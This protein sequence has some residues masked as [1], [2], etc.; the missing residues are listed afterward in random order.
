MKRLIKFQRTLRSN[1]WSSSN[2]VDLCHLYTFLSPP[3][4][5]STWNTHLVQDDYLI[6]IM[7]IIIY[8]VI[9]KPQLSYPS[10]RWR[11]P[12]SWNGHTL[13]LLPQNKWINKIMLITKPRMVIIYWTN[14]FLISILRSTPNYRCPNYYVG[15]RHVYCPHALQNQ[16][17]SA[18]IYIYIYRCIRPNWASMYIWPIGG[19]F[20]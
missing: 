16:M 4:S 12:C 1:S 6:Q 19:L 10:S 9:F 20:K 11:F 17:S 5:Y 7:S 2:D 15:I 13:L 8:I 3:T 14:V 18:Y